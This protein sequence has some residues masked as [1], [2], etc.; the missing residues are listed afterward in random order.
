M[1]EENIS[2]EDRTYPADEYTHDTTE[3]SRCGQ[4]HNGLTTHWFYQPVPEE[5]GKLE[6]LLW[7]WW[8]TCPL[9]G[10]PILIGDKSMEMLADE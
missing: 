8:A 10:D 5:H 6:G 2:L 4:S 9:T 1:S 7:A 3:C